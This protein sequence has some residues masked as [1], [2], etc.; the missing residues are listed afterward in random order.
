[1]DFTKL[2]LLGGITTVVSI[3]GAAYVTVGLGLHAK[4][5]RSVQSRQ[6]WEVV[7]FLAT[8]EIGIASGLAV[9]DWGAGIGAF[10]V[11]TSLLFVLYSYVKPRY[12]KRLSD[13]EFDCE[14][15]RG[16]YISLPV[17]HNTEHRGGRYD[18]PGF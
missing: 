15:R 4:W 11:A 8:L 16:E 10:I 6:I 3:A 12:E 18:K 7:V 14:Q 17:L 13:E 9:D 5:C 1:M 2:M